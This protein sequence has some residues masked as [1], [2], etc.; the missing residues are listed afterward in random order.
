MLVMLGACHPPS[1][2]APG[3]S[4]R[5]SSP[6]ATRNAGAIRCAPPPPPETAPHPV[7]GLI[8]AWRASLGEGTGE[9]HIDVT[10]GLVVARRQGGKS[11]SIDLETGAP[12]AT[13]V[14]GPRAGG[15]P[16]TIDPYTSRSVPLH[17]ALVGP[18]E[19]TI[20]AV[21]LGTGAPLWSRQ[22]IGVSGDYKDIYALRDAMQAVA[23]GPLGVIG[24]YVRHQDKD[25]FRFEELL[26]GVDPAT[27][28][29]RWRR[30]AVQH[31]W[32]DPLS[33]GGDMRLKTDGQRVIVETP[34]RLLAVDGATGA[35]AWSAPWP[36][37]RRRRAFVGAGRVLVTQPGSSLTLRDASDGKVLA[38]LPSPGRS[39]TDAVVRRG[40]VVVAVEE[41]PGRA[42]V[43]AIDASGRVQ[44]KRDAAYSV[45][46]LRG[47]EGEEPSAVYM[48]DGNARLWALDERTGAERGGMTAGAPHD[49]ALARA[50]GGGARVVLPVPGGGLAAFDLAPDSQPKALEP[51]LRW[52]FEARAAADGAVLCHPDEVARVDGDD[53]VVWRRRLPERTRATPW[54][55]CDDYEVVY[56][57]RRPRSAGLSLY[58]L[59]G[60]ATAGDADVVADA[61]GVL[62]LARKDGAVLLDRA[63]PR[64]DRAIFFDEGT[65][66]LDGGP[67]CAGPSRHGYVFAQ[68][69]SSLV[70][71]NGSTALLID[72]CAWRVEAE[73]ALTPAMVTSRGVKTEAA[74]PLGKRILS[75]RGITYMR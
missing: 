61:T 22:F 59:M 46:R 2:D 17:G 58:S 62:A 52:H 30:P 48:L 27:G 74:I 1:T 4:P 24:Y 47:I 60:A 65:F 32:N 6:Q 73:A 9:L 55:A 56:Y 50:R 40:S 28:E 57:L 21:D 72:A 5:P 75:L 38:E 41:A 69:G 45:A 43:V 20:A 54:G 18:S 23:A 19:L 70:Y 8:P 35:K 3:A 49:S 31:A 15:P 29:E 53:K 34:D 13:L 39:I 11:V 14:Q 44:W 63:A 67:P 66:A 51:F 33:M 42:F 25:R 26:V 16:P 68:C 10:R 36:R 7:T 12:C 37:E 64:D 71:F